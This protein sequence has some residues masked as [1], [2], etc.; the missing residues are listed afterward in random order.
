MQPNFLEAEYCEQLLS[1][2]RTTPGQP[3]LVLPTNE[4]HILSPQDDPEHRQ[5][6]Q[7]QLPEATTTTINQKLHQ[8]QPTLVNHFNL[9]LSGMQPLLFY[10]Y[11]QGSYFRV[12]CD[13]ST[14]PHAPHFLQ[15]RQISII[16]FLN[17][18]ASDP[19][20]GYYSG[21]SLIFY[22]LIDPSRWQ[23]HGFPFPAQA[24]ML[25]AFHSNIW[26]EVQTVLS[27]ERYTLVSW[28]I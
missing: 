24:G 7:L 9:S 13:S 28:Y 14:Q 27:G 22:G 1:T 3:A 10:R 5:T 15:A 18:P 8:L 20:P 16:I 6:E 2:V 26:H 25:V 23:S 21:G 4:Q 19:Q 11:T 12:H 17:S